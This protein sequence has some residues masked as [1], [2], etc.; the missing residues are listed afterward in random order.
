[1]KTSQTVRIDRYY[2][3]AK[4]YYQGK[5]YLVNEDIIRSIETKAVN[6]SDILKEKVT[7]Q[8]N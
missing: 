7:I 3:G 2:R 6:I 1:M 4:I 8:F 5:C